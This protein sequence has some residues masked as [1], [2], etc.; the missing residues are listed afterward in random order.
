MLGLGE[1]KNEI[2]NTIKDIKNAGC[3][4]ITIGQ[5]LQPSRN[6]LPVMRY[7]SPEEFKEYK[8]FALLTGFEF[9]ESGPLVRSSYHAEKHLSKNVD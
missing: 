6:H 5:Y 3:K 8:E 1:E 4:I 2:E 7:V 9:A